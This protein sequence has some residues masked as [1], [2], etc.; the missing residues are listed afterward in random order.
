MISNYFLKTIKALD[1]GNFLKQSDNIKLRVKL[2]SVISQCNYI[3]IHTCGQ[4]FNFYQ[5]P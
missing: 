5:I 2:T 4:I 3:T 1:L